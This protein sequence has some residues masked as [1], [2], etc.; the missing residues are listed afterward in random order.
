MKK[1]WILTCAVL[2]TLVLALTGL[3]FW[4]GVHHALFL[5]DR[6]EAWLDEDAGDVSLTLTYQQPGFSVDPDTG[7]F[8]P[9]VRQLLLSAEG[10]WTEYADR[11][12]YGL[13]AEGI[14]AYFH[15]GVMYMDTGRA[16]TLPDLMGLVKPT[17]KLVKGLIL[18]G[19]VTKKGDVY[20]VSM[21]RD[22]LE[23]SISVTA[24]EQVRALSA[25]AI[26]P[27]GTAVTGSVTPRQTQAHPIPQAVTDAMVRAK[28]EPPMPL[29]EPLE[30][31]LP[32]AEGLLPLSG[33]LELGVECG[34]LDLSETVG[35]RLDSK[36]AQLERRGTF[37]SIDLPQELSDM[38]PAALALL[39]L[40]NGEFSREGTSAVFRMTL[41]AETTDELCA[42][43]V[44]QIGELGIGFA[45][46]EAVLTITDGKL[47]AA[48]LTAEGSVPFLVTTIPVAFSAQ[49]NIQ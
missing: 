3:F 12:L 8:Q 31:L 22:G 39:V 41:P 7:R 46:S 2:L 32:A 23:L 49:L 45:G 13:T 36:Q 33:T 14:S 25:N 17:G 24:D 15:E 44:P 28:M 21:D 18:Y 48:A 47:T 16:Y 35:F 42:A 9:Q 34:I 26:L 6:L 19:R 30:I 38:D 29:M 40:R 10:F 1:G 37:V 4:K 27:D 11:T 20:T 43:L 5:A